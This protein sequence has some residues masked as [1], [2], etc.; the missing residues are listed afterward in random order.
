MLQKI[1]VTM[2]TT[3]LTLPSGVNINSEAMI[4]KG[5]VISET[6]MTELEGTDG[7]TWFVTDRLNDGEIVTVYTSDNGTSER[8]D[9]IIVAVERR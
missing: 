5:I 2:L 6:T 8:E 3:V 7:N 1:V 9:D 4:V